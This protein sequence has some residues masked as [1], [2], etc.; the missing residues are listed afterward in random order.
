MPN[1]YP[2]LLSPFKVGNTVFR[3]RLFSAPTGLHALQGN[4]P[5]PT[6]AIIETFAARARGGAAM[7]TL[8][9][10]SPFPVVSDGEHLS[11]DIYTAHSRHYLAQLAEMIHFYG[12][13]ASME[14]LGDSKNPDYSLMP[15]KAAPFV[16][17][18]LEMPDDIMDEIAENYA[19]QAEIMQY[20]GYDMVLVH[21]AYRMSVGARFL[22]PATNKRTDRYGGSVE[23]RARF[24]ITVFDRIKQRC[25][26]DFLI[27][28]RMSGAEPGPNG[29][30]IEDSIELARLLEG[31][32]DL[33]HVHAGDFADTHP[34]GFRPHLPNLGLAEA[35]KKS[36][37]TIP[38]I[39]IGG[40]QALDESEDIIATGKADF[41]SMARGW[42]ADPELG[43]KAY[44]DR[45][46]DVIPCIKC[47]RCHDSAC[48]DNR[49]YVCS[50]NPAIGLE[51]RLEKIV[52][53]PKEKRKIA[54]VGGGPAGME[55]ALVTSDRGHDV[56]L[57]EISHAL[58]GQLVFSDHVSF[59]TSLNKFKRYLLR[60]I[61]KS[62]V[63]VLLN[64]RAD[65]GLLEKGG[66]DVVIGALGAKPVVPPIPGIDSMNVITASEIYGKETTLAASVIVIGAGQVGCET[67]LHLAMSG[68]E[69]TLIEMQDRLAPDASMTYRH[70]LIREIRNNRNLRYILRAQ[71]TAIGDEVVYTDSAGKEKGVTAGTVVIATGMK[72]RLDEAMALWNA[73]D[74]FIMIGD[75]SEVGNVEKAMRSAFSAAIVL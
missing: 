10:V 2:H 32:V 28:L 46:E 62:K 11:Y 20:L 65:A 16:D 33:L 66:F 60:Q 57:F 31:R 55:A 29:I 47:M 35:I 5:Y 15:G 43:T 72:S 13:K 61:E 54:V 52:K 7:V 51:H 9:G 34:I 59:K 63:N 36:G 37:T 1:K 73:A 58:G 12:A 30:I 38:V 75:C 64:T 49:T 42:I 71:C 56:T 74:R 39:T 23:N 22:S 19:Y 50:V 44:E 24:P 17:P 69:V 27:E 70:T 18:I 25:G 48:L 41:I 6:E 8:H 26:K 3:N 67:A 4:E 68:H 45:G 21:M 53:P 40:N 14:I